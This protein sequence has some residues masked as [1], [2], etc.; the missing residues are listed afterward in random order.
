VSGETSRRPVRPFRRA[1]PWFVAAS[2]LAGLGVPAVGGAF[3]HLASIPAVGVARPLN[4]TELVVNMTDQPRFAPAYLTVAAGS[5]ATFHLVNQGSYAHTFTLLAQSGVVLNT[6]WTPTQV[7]QYVAANGS[8]ANVSVAPGAEANATVDFNS[9]TGFD[10]FEFLSLVPYQ[11]QAGMYGFVNVSSTEAG[12]LASENTTDSYSFVPDVLYASAPHYPFNLD[13]LVTNTGALGHTFTVEAQ[14][15]NTLSPANFTQYF[16]AHPPLV[17]A[18]VPSGAGGEVWANFTISG[19]GV[20]QYICTVSG[21]F[22]NGMTGQL[23]VGIPPPPPAP[24]PST[25]VVQGWILVGTGVLLT[26]GILLA[27]T[28]AYMG[29]FP[30]PERHEPHP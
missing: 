3:G 14:S 30:P 24:A 5:N 16:A 20:Y 18:V 4:S 27:A 17:N 7:D 23:Y 6:S 1:L 9:S 13:V 8:L 2:L 22:A 28:T 29:R 26:I 11:F 15:N 10:S 21:H 12:M 19:P 25:A